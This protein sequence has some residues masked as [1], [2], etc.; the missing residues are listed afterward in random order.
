[1]CSF[2]ELETLL[3][4][5]ADELSGEVF[6]VLMSLGEFSEFVSLMRSYTAQVAWET[7]T[8]AVRG[9]MGAA[10]AGT[11]ACVAGLA[12]VVTKVAR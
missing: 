9:G 11:P 6:D 4:S 5:H 3:T 8:A 2:G 7:G 1:M 10:A 12:P